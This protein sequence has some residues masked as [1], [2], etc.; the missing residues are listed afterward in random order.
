[1]VHFISYQYH[2]QSLTLK[3]PPDFL[4]DGI[5]G[6]DEC[7][8]ASQKDRRRLETSVIIPQLKTYPFA[9]PHLSKRARLD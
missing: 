9:G 5:T 7:F 1:M 6:L 3:L 8:F 2:C 4:R